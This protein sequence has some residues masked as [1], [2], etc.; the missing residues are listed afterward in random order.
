METKWV[1]WAFCEPN[2]C[3]YLHLRANFNLGKV[4]KS[5]FDV[6]YKKQDRKRTD[7]KQ[8]DTPKI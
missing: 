3:T 1:K 6:K 8:L 2:S 7:A 4:N 5:A